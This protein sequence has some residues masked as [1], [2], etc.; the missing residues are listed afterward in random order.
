[1]KL[2]IYFQLDYINQCILSWKE[3]CFNQSS[4]CQNIFLDNKLNSHCLFLLRQNFCVNRILV[5]VLGGLTWNYIYSIVF[6]QKVPF[7]L[8]VSSVHRTY[9][10]TSVLRTEGRAFCLPGC[11]PSGKCIERCSSCSYYLKKVVM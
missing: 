7:S 10:V 8:W 4:Y 6:L 3:K 2:N 1:M 5:I 9:C 11:S